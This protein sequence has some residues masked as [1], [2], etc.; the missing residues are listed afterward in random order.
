MLTHKGEEISKYLPHRY[1]NI[2]VDKVSIETEEIGHLTLQINEE[3]ALGRTLFMKEKDHGHKVLISPVMMEILA[4]GSIVSRNVILTNETVVFASI[5]DFEKHNDFL[6]NTPVYGTVSLISNKKGFLRY[7]GELFEGSGSS[8][9]I[10][11]SGDMLAFFTTGSLDQATPENTEPLTFPLNIP[12][13]SPSFKSS[14][15]HCAD[16]IR[17]L[18]DSAITTQYEYPKSHPLIKGHF[19]GNPLM[20]GVMQWMSVEDACLQFCEI[21]NLKNHTI[22]TCDA[23]LVTEIGTVISDIKG[24]KLEVWI[25]YPNRTNQAEIISTKK[26]SFRNVV[27][28]GEILFT[29]VENITKQ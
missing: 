2:L 8:K 24:L 18:S 14:W 26:I 6:I 1:E 16:S 22:L 29:R 27:R 13:K 5:S 7:R 10:I 12:I 25:D 28:P 17:Y 20:M 21:N 15:M 4:L 9:K 11:C 3:D 23:T 19:Q